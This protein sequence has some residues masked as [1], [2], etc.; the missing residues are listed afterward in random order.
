M[1]HI[2]CKLEFHH[3]FVRK[4]LYHCSENNQ[5]HFQ[6]NLY[7]HEVPNT[8]GRPVVV[9]VVVH[10]ERVVVEVV[11]VAQYLVE[12]RVVAEEPLVAE[13]RVVAEEPLVAEH[14][15]QLVRWVEEVGHQVAGV[16][17]ADQA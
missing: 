1:L 2:L 14:R 5:Y 3:T 4:S 11:E 7:Q 6:G 8:F 13:H 10:L 17:L 16:V 9:G 15:A 12:H